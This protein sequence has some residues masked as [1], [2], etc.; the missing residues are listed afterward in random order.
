M[1]LPRQVNL[2][3]LAFLIHKS[4]EETEAQVRVIK[5]R[6]LYAGYMDPTLADVAAEL[7]IGADE[8][9]VEG[10]NLVS[11]GIDTTVRRI[12]LTGFEVNPAVVGDTANQEAQAGAGTE[13]SPEVQ[14]AEAWLDSFYKNNRLDVISKELHRNTERDGEAFLIVDYDPEYE[15]PKDATKIGAVRCYSNQRYTSAENVWKTFQGDNEGCKAHYRNNDP[16]QQLDMVSK[17]WIEEFF[18]DE[19]IKQR[20]RMTLYIGEVGS[21]AAGDKI[22]SR[23]EKYVLG[24]SGEWDQWKDPEDQD[25]PIWWTEGQ[26]EA[27]V[28]LPLP[29][30]HFRNEAILPASKKIWGLQ[31]SMDQLWVSFINAQLTAGHQILVAFGF[32]PTTDEKPPAEDGSNLFRV[33]PRSILGTAT[34]SPREASLDAIQPAP[35]EPLMQALDKNAIDA[36]FVGGLPVSNFVYSKAVASSETLKQ[37]DAELIA[38]I[39]ELMG[40]W[41][42]SWV[43]A[44]NAARAVQNALG[45]GGGTLDI[46]VEMVPMWEQPERRDM[47]HLTREAAAKRNAGVPEYVILQE[48]W[49]YSPEQSAAYIQANLAEHQ[50]GIGPE[51][52]VPPGEANGQT[53]APTQEDPTNQNVQGAEHG[54]SAEQRSAV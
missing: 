11:I 14:E 10:I 3:E 16:N 8:T 36:S 29:V 13:T 42:Y 25:W 32:Y 6:E 9:D 35:A 5:G 17:R 50:L 45:E 30:I 26:S 47:N 41:T 4:D 21:D 49:G 52:T 22:K 24:D 15:D 38:R 39:N 31:N 19:E 20:S 18:E 43:T 40:L 51:V 44:L 37:G 27:G 53:Q 48:V 1:L 34:K 54:N 33:A 23:I 12:T 7:L 46:A 28:S 2:A